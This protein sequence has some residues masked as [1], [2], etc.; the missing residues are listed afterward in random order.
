[1]VD[2]RYA[3]QPY[4]VPEQHRS[5][6][7]ASSGL[8]Q[9]VNMPE[10]PHRRGVA[11]AALDDPEALA[12][13]TFDQY[14]QWGALDWK[15]PHGTAAAAERWA[16]KIMEEGVTEVLA[17]Y[18]RLEPGDNKPFDEKLI[19]EQGDVLFIAAAAATT[20][21][22]SLMH[23]VRLRLRD[24]YVAI[25]PPQPITLRMVDDLMADG[26]QPHPLGGV[27][28]EDYD[29]DPWGDDELAPDINWALL[30]AGIANKLRSGI[31]RRG[32]EKYFDPRPDQAHAIGGM[33]ADATLFIA[34]T[35]RRYGGS[36]LQEVVRHNFAKVGQRVSLNQ[37]DKT[38]NPR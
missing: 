15:A 5:R 28:V 12:A 7:D 1:M 29:D 35:A 3:T 21:S 27:V 33:A 22:K 17:E 9:P 19:D 2:N 38:D 23:A 26:F 13:M 25:R 14:Q 18:A 6:F 31:V 8:W 24:Q 20:V 30:S 32:P 11:G 36:N 4:Y 34:Y 10:L 16:D 37:I